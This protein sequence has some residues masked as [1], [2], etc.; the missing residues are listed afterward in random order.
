MEKGTIKP[1]ML[2][3]GLYVTAIAAIWTYYAVIKPKEK[4]I[5]MK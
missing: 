3:A 1:W 5:S 4:T 2:Y